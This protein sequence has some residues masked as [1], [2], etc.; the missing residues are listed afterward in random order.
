MI[1]KSYD[2]CGNYKENNNLKIKEKFIII[3]NPFTKTHNIPDWLK[4]KLFDYNVAPYQENKIEYGLL[5]LTN[6]PLTN[7]PLTNPP[8]T[9]PPLTNPPLTD[10]PLTNPPLTN[11][12]LT[13][14]PLTDPPLTNPPLTNPPL[15]DPPLTNPPLTDP[16]LTNPPLTDPPLTNPPLPVDINP[17]KKYRFVND[18]KLC[19]NLNIKSYNSS[20]NSSQLIFCRIKCNNDTNCKA[21]SFNTDT[22]I[23][24]LYDKKDYPDCTLLNN[25]YFYTLK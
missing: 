15:T 16:P 11:P 25:K 14:P 6:P 19:D 4:S 12:P 23:C 5:P 3:K 18:G 9:D 2:I 7:P 22:N 24:N 1:N 13:N 10:P 8:L 20:N 17:N 21:Y